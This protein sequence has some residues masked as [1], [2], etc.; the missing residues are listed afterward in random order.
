M[1]KLEKIKKETNKTH[2]KTIPLSYTG[3]LIRSPADS[4][5]SYGQRPLGSSTDFTQ[6]INIG[7]IPINEDHWR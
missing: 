6:F 4:N 3:E 1:P 5:F 2:I 7:H